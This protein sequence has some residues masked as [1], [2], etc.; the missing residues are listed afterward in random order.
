MKLDTHATCNKVQKYEIPHCHSKKLEQVE[1][2]GW[3]IFENF[4]FGIILI[5]SEHF[6]AIGNNA[7][8]LLN[9]TFRSTNIRSLE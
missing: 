7:R 1:V 5:F 9:S 8:A 3:K 2:S 6:N 4:T